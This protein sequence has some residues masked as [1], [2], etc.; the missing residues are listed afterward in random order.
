MTSRLP[1]ILCLLT[2]CSAP[3]RKDCIDWRTLTVRDEQCYAVYGKLICVEQ[4]VT[5]LQCVLWE[6]DDVAS[7]N[8]TRK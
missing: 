1:V 6:D 7:T 4:D 2:A 3:E 5:R 8:R